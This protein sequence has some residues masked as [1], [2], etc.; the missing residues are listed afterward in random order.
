M[1]QPDYELYCSDAHPAT[2]GAGVEGIDISQN[3]EDLA[4]FNAGR[5]ALKKSSPFGE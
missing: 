3:A 1:I 5:P 4:F 2:G